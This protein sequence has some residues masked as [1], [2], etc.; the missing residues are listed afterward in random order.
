MRYAQSVELPQIGGLPTKTSLSTCQQAKFHNGKPKNFGY[1]TNSADSC[2]QKSLPAGLLGL[3]LKQ[4]VICDREGSQIL[5]ISG[6]QIFRPSVSPPGAVK[7]STPPSTMN[8]LQ[9]PY[10]YVF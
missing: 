5:G 9:I 6:F 10:K 7:K 4:L 3:E 1:K 8:I 2:V